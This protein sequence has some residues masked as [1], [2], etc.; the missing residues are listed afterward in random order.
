M[1]QVF[2]RWRALW[3]MGFIPWKRFDPAEHTAPVEKMQLQHYCHS[4]TSDFFFFLRG[5]LLFSWLAVIL[6][7]IKIFMCPAHGLARER[8][9]WYVLIHC[10]CCDWKIHV[11]KSTFDCSYMECSS[12]LVW[13]WVDVWLLWMWL[14][15]EH[16]KNIETVQLYTTFLGEKKKDKRTVVTTWQQVS[17]VSVRGT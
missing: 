12:V 6:F 17:R 4:V 8:T 1:G 2:T 11:E 7:L 5:F 13:F 16:A 3:I 14:W 10:V 9:R 15:C